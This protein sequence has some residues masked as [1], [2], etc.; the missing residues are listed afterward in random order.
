VVAK[1]NMSGGHSS[2]T[3]RETCIK[4]R[5]TIDDLPASL[6]SFA[7]VYSTKQRKYN[8]HLILSIV[9]CVGFMWLVSSIF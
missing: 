8:L 7:E 1:R 2:V 6:G 4:H 9:S 5:M 3:P